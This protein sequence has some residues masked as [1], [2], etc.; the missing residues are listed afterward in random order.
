MKKFCSLQARLV[1]VTILFLSSQTIFSQTLFDSFGDG[2]FS[3]SP[4][5]GGS[6]GNWGVVAN[7]DAAAGA[8]GSNTVRLASTG[9]ATVYLSSQIA[10][11]S[12]SQEWGFWVGRR[13]QAYTGANQQYL[14]LYANEA[15]LTSAT[16]D[17]YRLAIGDDSG[18]DN[19]RLEYIVNGALSATVITSSGTISTGVTDVGFLVRVTRSSSGAWEIFT[20]TLPTVSSTGAIA[21]DV[22]NSSNANVSQGTATNNTLVPAT[23]GYIGIAALHSS[24]AAAIIANEIDQVY[25]TPGPPTID[26]TITAGEYGTHTN[27][28]NQ[29]TNTIT[30]YMTWDNTNLYIGIGAT[31]NNSDESAVFYFDVNPIVPVNGGTNANG[32]TTGFSAYDRCT[33]N[34]PFRADF[35]VYFKN[36]YYEYRTANGSGGWSSQ[37]TTGLTYAQSG[38]GA[39]QSQEISIPWSVMPS[40]TRPAAFNWN[41]KKMWDVSSSNNGVY[42][43]LPAANPGGAQNVAAYTINDEYYYTVSTTTIGSSTPPMSRVSF[44]QPLGVTNNT[45]GAIT[46]WDFTMNSSGQQIA[47]L[48]T[49]G[50]W[51]ISNSLVV[52]SGTLYFGSG[53]SGY[54]TTSVGS[55]NVVGGSLNMDQTNQSLNVTGD[56][57]IAG[58]TLALSGTSGGDLALGGNWIFSSGTFTPN[59]RAVTFNSSTAAQT[60]TGNTTFDYL[61]VNNTFGTPTLTLQAS[62]AV[63][64]N[65]NVNFTNGRIV[66]GANNLTLG[67]SATV[68]TPTTSK[69]FVTNSTGVLIRPVSTSAVTFNVGNSSYNPITLTPSAGTNIPYQVRV[70]DAVTTPAPFVAAKLINR[71]WNIAAPTAGANTLTMDGQ[72]NTGEANGSYAAGTQVKVAYHNGTAWTET[73]STQAGANPF[74]SSGAFAVTAGDINAGITFGIGKDDGF[75]NA[76]VSYTWN[77]GTDNDWGTSANWTPAG[78]PG[79]ADNVIINIPG[80]NTLSINSSRTVVD[81][82]V[83]G[84][85]VFTTTSAGALTITGAPTSSTSATITLDCASTVNISSASS[86]TIPAWNYGNLNTTGGDR[87]WTNGATTNICGNFV[88]GA[89]AFTVTGSTV[90][91]NGTAAQAI[92]TNAASFATL[93]ITNTAATVTANANVTASTAMTINSS[94]VFNQASGTLTVSSATVNVNGTLRNST[95]NNI[96]QTSATITVGSTGTYDHNRNTAGAIITATW[97]TG[98]N[99][100]ITG[101]P[102]A[103]PNAGLSQSFSDFTWSAAMST[104]FSLSS[105]LTT[106]N[107]D[108]I[109]TTTNAQN[110]GL[111]ATTG[112]VLNVG[113]DV[114]IQGGNVICV[115]GNNLNTVDINVAEDLFITGAGSLIIAGSSS[116]GVGTTTFDVTDSVVVNSTSTSALVL[117]DNTKILSMTVGNSFT[118]TNS[119][120]CSLQDGT[121]SANLTITSGNLNIQAGTFNM[122]S[123]STGFAQLNQS[124]SSHGMILSGGTFNGIGSAAGNV[125]T[126]NRPIV[127]LSGSFTQS[128]TGIFEFAAG[129]V[130]TSANPVGE[131]R[132][133]GDFTRSGSGDMT[134]TSVNAPNNGLIVFNGTAQDYDETGVSGDFSYVNSQVNSGSTV[135]LLT[136]MTLYGNPQLVTVLSGGSLDFSTFKITSA[137]ALG[138]TFNVNS[139]GTII[140]ANQYG[141]TRYQ[142][143]STGGSVQLNTRTYNSGANYVFNGASAQGTGNFWSGTT[144]AANT[145]NN[146]TVN[147]SSNVTL[148]TLGTVNGTLTLTSGHLILG[149]YNLTAAAISGATSSKHIKTTGTGLLRQGVGSPGATGGILFP[150]GNSAYNPIT[151]TYSGI[152]DA[153]GIRVIDGAVAAANDATKAVNR[154][155]VI[156]E[157]LAGSSNLAVV[158][159]Y[160]SGEEGTNFAAGTTPYIGFYKG[161]PLWVQQSATPAGSGPFTYTSGANFTP[162]NLTTGTQYFA[163]G[164]DDAF[165]A[166]VTAYSWNGSTDNSWAT[167]ANWTPSGTPGA[168]DNVVIDSTGV[169]PL[170]IASTAQVCS[171][172]T[173]SG[174]G[175]FSITGTGSLTVAAA[176]TV[177]SSATPTFACGSSFV[178]SS[179]SSQPVPA[180]NYGNLDISG[181]GRTLASSGTIGVCGTYTP[182]SPMTITGSTID[183]NGSGAQS[184]AASTYN[185]LTISQNRGG[186]AITLPSGTI[187]VAGTF[188]PS[189]SNFTVTTSTN[190]FNFSSASAQNFP[191]FF[192]YNVTNSGNG[193]RTW[194]NSGVID[195]NNTLTPGT[196]THT[197]T[198]S[199]MRYS[200]TAAATITLASFT[201][202]ITTPARQYNNLEIGGGASTIFALTAGF[203]LGV[204]N[205]FTYTGAGAF[206]I[207]SSTSSNAM[208]VD[209]ALSKTGTGT[210]RISGSATNGVT[211]SLTVTGNSTLSSGILEVIAT[212]ATSA[213]G[214]FTTNDLTIDG[215][216]QMVLETVSSTGTAIVT[217]NGDLSVSSTTANAI[218]IGAGTANANN[219]IALKRDFTKSGTGT[220]GFT[221]STAASSGYTFSGVVAQTFNHSGAAMTAGNITVAAGS[222]LQLQTNMTMGSAG[223]SALNVAGILDADAFQVISG[224]ASDQFTLNATGT[225]ITASATGVAG[226]ISGFTIFPAFTS[227]GTFEFT[228]TN[229]NTGFATFANISATY[230]MNW[231]GSGSL[232]LDKNISLTN[233]NFTNSGL[234]YLGTFNMTISS[235]GGITGGS[236]SASKMIVTNSTGTLIRTISSPLSA[237]VPFTWPIGDTLGVDEYSPVT[238]SATGFTNSIAGS[239]GFKVTDGIQSAMGA[240]TSYLSRYW[241]YTTTGLGAYAWPNSTFTYAAA[242]IVVGPEASLRTSIYDPNNFS[243]TEMASSSGGSNVLT[244]TTG[245]FYTSAAN[246][247]VITGADI[248]GRI[249]VPLY[250][251]T[252]AAGP[253]SWATPAT[254]EASASPA[255][256]S[257]FTPAAPPTAAN[258][259]LIRVNAGHTVTVTSSTSADDLTVDGTID[260]SGATTVF[261]VANGTAATDATISATGT[262]VASTNSTSLVFSS[263]ASTSVNGLLRIVGS[264]AASGASITNTG[265]TINMNS[266]S[267]YDHARDGGTLTMG[268]TVNW[269]AGSTCR[270]SGMTLNIPTVASWGQSFANL[271]VH[272]NISSTLQVS[273]NLT[274]VNG[275][276]RVTSTGAGALRLAATQTYALNVGGVMEIA[277]AGN[278]DVTSG[279]GA[280]TITVADSLI[281]AGTLNKTGGGNS[282][283]HLNGDLY[284]PT[285]GVFNFTSVSTATTVNLRGNLT[286]DGLILRNNGTATLNFVKLSGGTQTWSQTGG[287]VSGGFVFNIGNATTNTVQMLTDVNVGTSGVTSVVVASGATLDFQDKILTGLNAIFNMGATATLKI[288]SQ[289]GITTA[290]ASPTAGNLQTL[291][292]QR[293]VN[294]TS[295]YVYSGSVNQVT[296]NL[297]PVTLTTTGKLNIAN[298]GTSGN[299]TVTL[300]T[301][302]ATTPALNLI[303]GLFAAGTSQSLNITSGGTVAATSG[304]FAVGSTAGI[305]NFP[306]SGTFSGSCNPYNVYTSG[307]VNFGAGT[308]TIQN[309]G[310]FRINN[311]GFVNTNAPF[312]HSN[313]TLQYFINSLGTYG[314][315]LE[316]SAASGRGYPGNV[317][318]SNNNTLDPSNVNVNASVVLNCSGSLTIDSGSSMYMDLGGNN[319]LVD[320]NVLGSVN[321]NG[322]LSGSGAA[323]SDIYVGRDWNN[324]GSGVNF[325]PNSRAVFLNGTLD[326]TI[327]GSN[328][329]F[330]AF[331]F[332]LIDKAS[333]NVSLGRN[334]E[335]SNTLTYTGANTAF[336]D[337]DIYTLYVSNNATTSIVRTGAGHVVG[338]LRRAFNTGTNTYNFTVGDTLLYSPVSIAANAVSVAGSMT[339]FTTSGDHPQIA[340]SGLESTKSVNRIWTLSQ[341]GLTLTDYNP[342]FTF[343]NPADL[344]GGVTTSNLLVGR[345]DA[346]VWTTPTIG[347][348]TSTTT[349][350]TG[351]TGYGSF[352]VAECKTPAIYSVT[353]G[354]TFC[355]SSSVGLSNSETFVSY[356]LQLNG[357]DLGSPIVGTGSA[358]SFTGLTASGTY[359]I[360]GD[361]TNFASCSST[362]SGSAVLIITP[363]VTPTVTIT[364]SPASTICTGTSVTFTAT[365]NFGGVS[366]SYQW[367]LNG[368]NV[369]ANSPTYVNA[370]LAD[371][372]SVRVVMT[373][374]TTVCPSPATATSNTIVMTVL[375]YETPYLVIDVMP[376]STICGGQNATFITFPSFGGGSPSYQWKINGSNVGTNSSTYS[377]ST[378]ANGDLVSC[379]LTSDYLCVTSPTATSNVIDMTVIAPAQAD[380]GTPMSTCGLTAYTFANGATVSNHLSYSWS[381]TGAGS[382]TAGG[383]SLTPTYTPAAGDLGNTVTFTL[384]A[385]GNSPCASVSD[386][387]TLAV[388]ALVLFYDDDDGD[389]FGDPLST[390]VAAC[391]APVGKVSNSSD[392]CDTDA[393]INP[394]T[395][396][397]ADIDGDGF[398]SFVYTIGCISG[399]SGPAQTIPY[400]A[401]AHGDTLYHP[402]CNDNSITAYPGATEI[403]QNNIDENCNGSGTDEG[404]SGLANDNYLTMQYAIN[405]LNP[406]TYYPNCLVYNGTIVNAAISPEG[407]PANVTAGAGRDIWYRFQAPSTGVQIKVAPNGFDAVI[408]L[409]TAPHPATQVDVENASTGTSPTPTNGLEILNTNALTIGQTYYVGVRNYNNTNVGTFTICVSPLMPSGCAYVEPV[410]GFALVREL[411]SDLSRSYELHI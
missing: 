397:W 235:T 238:I 64:V 18:G 192:Y 91:F 388:N 203:N 298:T 144:A 79:A 60:L 283:F 390:P 102:N 110:L 140:T 321:V 193:N 304:D 66:L 206:R 202:N 98:S 310:T 26:G 190:T 230:T 17:G 169:N 327:V 314:R 255:F 369:G 155:W 364:A 87:I 220:L 74:N 20:S 245:P 395:E 27:G 324:G 328:A 142:T 396:W 186:A 291:V 325:F 29:E 306:G 141:F 277:A 57:T 294:S 16:V 82:T 343:N 109:V 290:L 386:V 288:G 172:F 121:G 12:S 315:G 329:S 342:T 399:C 1:A 221:G 191:A 178:L 222:E 392:C 244:T 270:V 38:A 195:I 84:T 297:L 94:A 69:Y 170:I 236:F 181:G 249:D 31:S 326:Q 149:N 162:S 145:V 171:D 197:I 25:F 101:T 93:N 352:A 274:T 11:W 50:N 158:A 137:A 287:T 104:G 90:A 253:S 242:D 248:T 92:N 70:I 256:T 161:S 394:L 143:G 280:P 264:T 167:A 188:N 312:Y 262:L 410:G 58:G 353:G 196:G 71:Y 68:S 319:M 350:A 54:G 52:G 409:R 218:N 345:Y 385:V 123:G 114:R 301:S 211:G 133:A 33:V 336:I 168:S 22:P 146:L 45:F 233:F 160:N 366:P 65:T 61:T 285:G 117:N 97:N 237:S 356:Q 406:N 152:I 293:N 174:T 367:K 295:T 334:V 320:L 44:T 247:N 260:V 201:T 32:S 359:T 349:Q 252:V 21:T 281:V 250:Y 278:L 213:N 360:I 180:W 332:L 9:A 215:T 131:L 267:T 126:A 387:V 259:V 333:G 75:I 223:N 76:A 365:P 148:D 209:G 318:V 86:R 130:T 361:N 340:T 194:A 346:S 37:T 232:T 200:S 382:I 401:A 275:N 118:K 207:A 358:I 35:V 210:L 229:V 251:Q 182:G 164:K 5:W 411:Q 120:T 341:T 185:N 292:A 225:L 122:V 53:G 6:T 309:N 261:T 184:I 128:G 219:Q 166:P 389:G 226:T 313:S 263:G 322:N 276:F 216:G 106:V 289:Y 204:A 129:S 136:D 72:W 205:N 154:S 51:A 407:N 96:V 177:S 105:G 47:R 7:S 112:L 108:L 176:L 381:E 241:S 208:A 351:L 115:T 103:A 39:G 240:A 3:S 15:N 49:G 265:A 279:T 224:N 95:A 347:T 217:V 77:G 377:T 403:C 335:V 88:A 8:T 303:S 284:Q 363:T 83:S 55:V 231:T 338:N 323:G 189:V 379:V 107:R 10:N 272:S 227:G 48:N 384:T 348:R 81:F 62:S 124:S 163:I 42:G 282:I 151:L 375:A 246:Y 80:T 371:G 85:G 63:T 43:E 373:A 99:C 355:G 125:L 374:D 378:L 300:T 307:G 159:Q 78:I 254:W 113:R 357:V 156:T 372:D 30:S 316:W 258:S 116:A 398:G 165:L 157:T 41:S 376:D 138:T 331:P 4:T 100:L 370:A 257:P 135:T 183:F 40:G 150:V 119:G 243:W 2:N 199:T 73:N 89:G 305:L 317:K 127:N 212:T 239:I 234:V 362:M 404:C 179:A 337:A 153:Y 198:G 59:T 19:I 354:G 344:D 271:T 187:D 393:D 23:N 308:V 311:G 228:G 134:V 400:Y 380:A 46:V 56:V 214:T 339:A 139:G 173:L 405:T 391:A 14:W 266:G 402:D 408:E 24:G 273:G 368:S 296:G 28:Q 175:N 268:G 36:G 132:V 299:N 383:T 111:T 13:G 269:N 67:A 34:L 302:G 330:P 286:Q 147:N